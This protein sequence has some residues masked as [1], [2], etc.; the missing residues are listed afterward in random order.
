MSIADLLRRLPQ[1]A[2]WAGR[3]KKN[4]PLEVNIPYLGKQR[5]EDPLDFDELFAA[6]RRSQADIYDQTYA[7]IRKQLERYEGQT[8]RLPTGRL[9]TGRQ[10]PE[11]YPKSPKLVIPGETRRPTL[12]DFLLEHIMRPRETGYKPG[13]RVKDFGKRREGPI[14]ASDPLVSQG[15]NVKFGR[16]PLIDKGFRSGGQRWQG[17]DVK[18]T[19]NI[20]SA[21]MYQTLPAT[22]KYLPDDPEFMASTIKASTHWLRNRGLP[23]AMRAMNRSML[24]RGKRTDRQIVDDILKI[25]DEASPVE[26]E[27]ASFDMM[28]A[29]K[30][31]MISNAAFNRIVNNPKAAATIQSVYVQANRIRAMQEVLEQFGYGGQRKL[32]D[33]SGMLFQRS[34]RLAKALESPG[35]DYNFNA[36][37]RDWKDLEKFLTKFGREAFRVT[38]RMGHARYHLPEPPN[39]SH[40]FGGQTSLPSQQFVPQVAQRNAPPVGRLPDSMRHWGRGWT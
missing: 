25:Y 33:I 2:R 18:L 32:H 4:A 27:V 34:Q 26:A 10:R 20:P 29:M 17:E 11:V 13:T 9:G 15:A 19:G 12:D 16:K 6:Q 35:G 22:G 28:Q 8:G 1:A 21:Q 40:Q 14:H 39:L 23:G 37:L 36:E 31:D 7:S 3:S 24:D 5:A 38:T 30:R